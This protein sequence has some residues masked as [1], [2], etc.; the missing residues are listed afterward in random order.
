MLRALGCPILTVGSAVE[1]DPSGWDRRLPAFDIEIPGDISAAAFLLVAAQIV[2]G[3]R[4]TARGVGVNP[5]RT[6]LLEIAR[7]MG[8]GLAIEPQGERGGEPVAE[9][10][11][12]S[13]PLRCVV[14]GGETVPRAIDEIPI[15]CALA[16][17]AKGKTRIGDADELR[18]K[19]SDRISTMASV[20]RA[21]GISCEE[22]PDGLDIEGRA[23]ALDPADVDS[24]GDH[25]IAM[26]AAVLALVARAPSRVRDAACIA[27]S[28]P[29]FVAT[30]RALG[31]T[32]DVEP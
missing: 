24:R 12:W 32:I 10:H 13:A 18:H 16:A 3:S 15:A 26:T 27:T 7:D 21:F 11:A 2:E 29:K 30:L 9:L 6:G 22:R 19:E 17:R 4:V 20:L 8:A 1:L 14:I 25:R 31:A 28:Y 5:T 23:E